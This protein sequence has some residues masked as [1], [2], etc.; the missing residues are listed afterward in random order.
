MNVKAWQPFGIEFSFLFNFDLEALKKNNPN[1][2][3]ESRLSE[4]DMVTACINLL[5]YQLGKEA[6]FNP[7][8][9]HW[10]S[11]NVHNDE[12]AIEISSPVFKSWED[13]LAFYRF[14]QE[15]AKLFPLA[16]HRDDTY[17]GGG[18]IHIDIN[19][20]S[21]FGRKL[22][23]ETYF[24]FLSSVYIDIGNRPYLNWIFNEWC[25]E[26][27]AEG[28]YKFVG[29]AE[30]G[31]SETNMRASLRKI[32]L[33]N[34]H[35]TVRDIYKQQ[36]AEWKASRRE[37]LVQIPYLFQLP[38]GYA[39]KTCP[40]YKTLEFRFFDMA[41]SEEQLMA[42]VQFVQSY[43]HRA[44]NKTIADRHTHLM[45]SFSIRTV[46]EVKAL[47]HKNQCLRLF[48]QLLLSIGLK[49]DDYRQI[50]K[51]NYQERKR[52]GVMR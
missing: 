23:P 3:F 9:A 44:L 49:P 46:K 19:P 20:A 36:A 10:R 21:I 13:C 5:K 25:D 31:Y 27:S 39:I 6:T 1:N 40:E 30:D 52:R 11:A 16:T 41:R 14:I 42:H 12:D 26:N 33:R 47:A 2:A 8:K 28:L 43:M 4:S 51:L 38:K 45:P 15:Q 24:A 34:E 17:S 22:D 35:Q 7:K 18:H 29:T 32:M 48:D 50:V 37:P